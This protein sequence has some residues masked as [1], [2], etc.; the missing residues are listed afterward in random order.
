MS[1]ESQLPAAALIGRWS[2]VSFE[3][4]S[5]GHTGYPFGPNAVGRLTYDGAGQM[6]VQIMK[7]GRPLFASDDQ[8]DGTVEEVSAAFAGYAAY[9]GTYSVDE[10]EAVVVHH[11][12]A[13]LF[14][15]W[16]G[17]DQRRKALLEGSRL[18][19]STPP[20]RDRGREWI[21]RLVWRRMQ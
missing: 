19:L 2:L 10:R 20:M 15:N 21:F 12:V 6:A 4:V 3:A 17:S 18:T 9:Y 13:S 1:S 7:T 11:V 8:G 16:V 14:P 5:G